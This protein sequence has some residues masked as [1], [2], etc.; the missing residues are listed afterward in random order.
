LSSHRSLAAPP[1]DRCRHAPE[2][3][4]RCLSPKQRKSAWM[5]HSASTNSYLTSLQSSPMTL[6]IAFFTLSW[7]NGRAQISPSNTYIFA[8]RL[9]AKKWLRD[10]YKILHLKGIIDDGL[11]KYRVIASRIKE[12]GLRGQS[13]KKVKKKKN[14]KFLQWLLTQWF[15]ATG[16][17][18]TY[19]R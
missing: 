18:P 15:P 7:M 4:N 3:A 19:G 2:L 16:H 11:K 8:L 5:M 14:G 10:N 13:V 17:K 1:R 9:Y 12:A 6:C